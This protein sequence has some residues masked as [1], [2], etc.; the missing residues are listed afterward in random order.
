M[1]NKHS[2]PKYPPIDQLFQDVGCVAQSVPDYNVSS[3]D[4]APFYMEYFEIRSPNNGNGNNMMTNTTSSYDGMKN[5]VIARL[6]RLKLVAAPVYLLTAYDAGRQ[7]IVCRLFFP[8]MVRNII[9]MKDEDATTN[10]DS[11]S[12]TDYISKL[13]SLIN[14]I[15]NYNV[16]SVNDPNVTNPLDDENLR[17]RIELK[18]YLRTLGYTIKESSAP[19]RKASNAL[20]GA[21]LPKFKLTFTSSDSKID[22]GALSFSKQEDTTVTSAPLPIQDPDAIALKAPNASTL[23]NSHLWMTNLL[24]GMGHYVKPYSSCMVRIPRTKEAYVE[25]FVGTHTFDYYSK[26]LPTKIPGKRPKDE[27][28]ESRS[29]MHGCVRDNPKNTQCRQSKKVHKGMGIYNKKKTSKEY[30]IA[31]F[32]AYLI[33]PSDYRV[34]RYIDPTSPTRLMR[35]ILPSF[36][37]I[38]P[39]CRYAL[40]SPNQTYLYVLSKKGFTLFWNNQGVDYVDLCKRRKPIRGV[41]P[42]FIRRFI[43]GFDTRM[44]IE[45]DTLNIYSKMS[46]DGEEI[47][48]YSVVISNT[49]EGAPFTMIL[50]NDGTFDVFDVNNKNVTNA[51]FKA[52]N[53]AEAMGDLNGNNGFN[54]TN[55]N[56]G[57]TDLQIRILNLK[58][59][60]R[61]RGYAMLEKEVDN[62]FNLD[63]RTSVA[64]IINNLMK[65]NAN[66]RSLTEYNSKINYQIRLEELLLYLLRSKAITKPEYD[67]EMEKIAAYKKKL[68][69]NLTEAIKSN[70]SLFNFNFNIPSTG[71]GDINMGNIL[72]ELMGFDMTDMAEDIMD[73]TMEDDEIAAQ[74]AQDAEDK[75]QD[76]ERQY[77]KD[78]SSHEEMAANEPSD[79]YSPFSPSSGVLVPIDEDSYEGMLDTS[80]FGNIFG[81]FDFKSDNSFDNLLGDWSEARKEQMR[82]N[83]LLERIRVIQLNYYLT[84]KYRN[85]NPSGNAQ[86]YQNANMDL[87]NRRY[88]LL[89]AEADKINIVVPNFR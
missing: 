40:I 46:K 18:D 47:L 22:T 30:P 88:P 3:L 55:L 35:N 37:E 20:I 5:E 53:D 84:D 79:S 32:R 81:K 63:K 6:A 12:S 66:S 10:N 70:K 65:N 68:Y 57:L 85:S 45:E 44:V 78:K 33:N 34:V 9:L 28:N 54:N 86:D 69:E 67:L 58:A 41:T 62:S 72:D 17:R 11:L 16:F 71:L 64:T 27:L 49:K 25:G 13:N 39:G 42:L 56:G 82:Q 24:Y 2:T 89:T 48:G 59:Y 31:Y 77:E 75:E 4:N 87:I 50:N 26:P 60:L 8:S 51:A 52:N 29:F 23:G 73:S 36:L 21:N 80:S 15:N 43:G 19:V 1:G 38:T 14:R 7:V 61:L 83:R 76:N 74:K